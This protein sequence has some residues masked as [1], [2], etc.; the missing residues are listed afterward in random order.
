M[1]KTELDCFIFSTEESFKRPFTADPLHGLSSHNPQTLFSCTSTSGSRGTERHRSHPALG[2]A[3]FPGHNRWSIAVCR[4]PPR[5]RGAEGHSTVPTPCPNPGRAL[6]S[7]ATAPARPRPAISAQAGRR[8]AS[9]KVAALREAFL[10]PPSRRQAQPPLNSPR[11]S[12]TPRRHSLGAAILA[13][14]KLASLLSEAIGE[15]QPC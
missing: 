3:A 5:G 11:C 10:F 14:G 2:H 9:L 4:L 12:P 7:L 15:R 1:K 6:R 8:P 13:E